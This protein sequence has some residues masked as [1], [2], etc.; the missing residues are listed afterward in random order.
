M[1]GE[2]EALARARDADAKEVVQ[3]PEIFDGEL[4]LQLVD[5]AAEQRSRGGREH[6]VVHVQQ[7]VGGACWLMKNEQRRV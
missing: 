5:D 7:K 1:L 3:S 4:V 6:D 2:E